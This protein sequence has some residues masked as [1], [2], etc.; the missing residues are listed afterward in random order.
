MS[1]N[2]IIILLSGFP[3]RRTDKMQQTCSQTGKKSAGSVWKYWWIDG[4]IIDET[5]PASGSFR[6]EN[7]SQRKSR[8]EQYQIGLWPKLKYLVSNP[9]CELV[10]RS[11]FWLQVS[12]FLLQT[13]ICSVLKTWEYS[14]SIW[15]FIG[16]SFHLNLVFYRME[17]RWKWWWWGLIMSHISE[18]PLLDVLCSLMGKVWCSNKLTRS[19][20]CRNPP[21]LASRN[22]LAGNK[23]VQKF[24][25]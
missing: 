12:D 13:A 16:Y 7:Y 22:L 15:Y 21:K 18:V 25:Q 17:C 5:R 8:S 3:L 11:W 2:T 14:I 23:K 19:S 6:I 10:H 24:H 1:E 4:N 20:S 9:V